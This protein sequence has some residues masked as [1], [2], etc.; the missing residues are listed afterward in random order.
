MAKSDLKRVL[1]GSSALL[2]FIKGEPGGWDAL[3]RAER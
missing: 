3:L 2:A 1:L